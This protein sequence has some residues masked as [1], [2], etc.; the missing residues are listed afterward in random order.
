MDTLAILALYDEQER[1]QGTHSLYRREETP[2]VVRHIC[3]LPNRLHFVIYSQLTAVT[4]N[5]V[6]QEQITYFQSIGGSGLEWKVY[7]HDQP[8]D[9]K[10]RLS[11]HGFEPDEAEGLLVLDME[12]APDSY[13]QPVTADVR[14]VTTIVQIRDIVAIQQQVWGHD[15]HWLEEQLSEFL[16]EPEQWSVYLVYL[17]GKP[18][19]G[20]WA[21]FPPGSQFAGM[22]GGATLVDYRGRGAYTA[23]VNTR[24]QEARQRGYR[25]L[26]IDASDMSRAILQK[27]GFRFLTNTYPY[28][29]KP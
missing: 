1:R 28:T 3:T 6:I 10:E 14:R 15:F 13:W 29:W 18:V 23:V 11:A 12:E 5:R 9:L 20:A 4:A 26:M 2:D 19:C 17:D 27:R 22:W 16:K 25:F 21:S 24:A 8:S 7:D